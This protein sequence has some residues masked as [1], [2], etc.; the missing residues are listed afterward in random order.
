VSL[1]RFFRRG[2]WDDER[3]REL[4]P[5]VAIETDDNIARGEWITR[6]VEREV[7]ARACRGV[8]G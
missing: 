2:R 6:K 4:D 1:R 8:R 3:A 5:Y 7:R